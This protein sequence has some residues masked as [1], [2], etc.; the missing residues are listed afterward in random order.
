MNSSSRLTSSRKTHGVCV[1][2]S[3]QA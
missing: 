1:N 3:T 2:D